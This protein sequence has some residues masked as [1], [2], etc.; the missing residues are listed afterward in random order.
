M[1][2]QVKA[3][4]PGIQVITVDSSSESLNLEQRKL[5]NTV[6]EQYMQELALG[7]PAQLLL[8]VDSVAGSGKTY[9]LLKI[10]AQIQE[11]TVEAGK[12]NPV[13]QAAP[14]GIAA[15]N[16][17]GKTL[18]SLLQLPVKGKKSD[19]SVAILQSLQTLF[20]N[21]WF[22]IINKKSMIDLKMLS[23]IDDHLQVICPASHQP[24]RGINI[25]LCSGF[26]QLLP[27]RGQPLYSSR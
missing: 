26:F 25:L 8:N 11:L 14:T 2:E 24:F 15:F 9:T 17:V 1:W 3:A 18:H 4:N 5:Y 19:L 12:Q 22:L 16:I 23:L 21:C 7:Q 27:I 20:Q 13:F 6:V 10:C